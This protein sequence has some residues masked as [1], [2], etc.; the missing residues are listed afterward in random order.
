MN[1][2]R[3][4]ASGKRL[5]AKTPAKIP[6]PHGGA[7]YAGGVPGHRGGGGRP[8]SVVQQALVEGAAKAVPKLVAQLEDEDKAVAQ[9][10]ADKLIKYG[11]G[12]RKDVTITADDVRDRLERS[13]Q[14]IRRHAPGEIAERILKEM[15]EQWTN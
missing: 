11:I 1:S 14:I 5:D 10:A 4:P 12:T 6:Q 7:L 15:K 3:K 2:R 8:R 13:I 9:G